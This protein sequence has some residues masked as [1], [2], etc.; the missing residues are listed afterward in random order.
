[1]NA[2][3]SVSIR[4]IPETDASAKTIALF[5]GLVFGSSLCVE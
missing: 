2:L 3:S 1:M 4:A 5:C